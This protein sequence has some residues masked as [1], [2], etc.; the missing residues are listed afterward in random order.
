MPPLGVQAGMTLAFIEREERLE[1]LGEGVE[2]LP[3]LVAQEVI[4]ML[5][6]RR[7]IPLLGA[8]LQLGQILLSPRGL[9]QRHS[10]LEIGVV[11]EGAMGL[12]WRGHLTVCQARSVVLIPPRC[13]HLPHVPL[14]QTLAHRV[15]WLIFPPHQCIAH[16]C[17]WG[18]GGA[19]Y[20]HLL[21]FRRRTDSPWTEF[22][23]RVA[24]AGRM[25][26][27]RR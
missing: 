1:P 9:L 23:A 18:D 2:R 11:L 8:P 19:L 21:R 15:L 25:V 13:P 12:W 16:Q 6:F 4:P 26:A 10:F 17:A 3:R 27:P 22:M 20:R 24:P 14:P 7:H 5:E